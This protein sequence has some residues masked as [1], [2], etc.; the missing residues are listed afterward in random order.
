MIAFR[1]ASAPDLAK[2]AALEAAATPHGWSEPQFR[3]SL[4]AGHAFLLLEIDGEVC[5]HAVSMTVLDEAEL[6]TIVIAPDRQGQGLGQTLLGELLQ[7]LRRQ[8]CSRLFL[9]VRES[10][11]PARAL[12]AK[13]G[14][15]ETGLR[16]HYYPTASG[17]EHAV[18]ME[19][20]L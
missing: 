1:P 5:G 11:R 19:L 13:S 7:Q 9:E 2:L 20:E 15:V 17:R 16:K 14:F 4:E 3:G 12:Y 8:G 18:L 10:N 6:L